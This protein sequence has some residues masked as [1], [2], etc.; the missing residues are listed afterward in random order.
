[1][2]LDLHRKSTPR[3]LNDLHIK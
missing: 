2:G 3:T 1:M